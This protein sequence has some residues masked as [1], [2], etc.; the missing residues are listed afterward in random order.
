MN[1]LASERGCGP[2]KALLDSAQVV[3]VYMQTLFFAPA[4]LTNDLE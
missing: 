3:N 2:L 4:N 1:Y